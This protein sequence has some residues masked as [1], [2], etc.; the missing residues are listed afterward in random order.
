MRPRHPL[1]TS[2][3]RPPPT[4]VDGSVCGGAVTSPA[5]AT[6]LLADNRDHLN[7]HAAV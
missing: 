3:E 7:R 6:R 4:S 5:V 2:C 1:G